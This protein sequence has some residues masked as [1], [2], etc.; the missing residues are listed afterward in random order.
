MKQ[1][2]DV[3]RR[4]GGGGEEEEGVARAMALVYRFSSNLTNDKTSFGAK[5]A[6]GLEHFGCW[7]RLYGL[8]NVGC[9]GLQIPNVFQTC[10]AA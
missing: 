1:T 9:K 10:F 3:F 2:I 6:T 7:P 8:H 4:G 5:T